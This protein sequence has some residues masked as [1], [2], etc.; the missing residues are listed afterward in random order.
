MVAPKRPSSR[1]RSTSGCGYSSACSYRLA[2]GITSRSTKRRTVS[3][4]CAVSCW[5]SSKVPPRVADF[6]MFDYGGQM[7]RIA[8]VVLLAV[9]AAA[10]RERVGAHP[11]DETEVFTG[12][13]EVE[14]GEAPKR[15]ALAYW[16]VRATLRVPPA[17]R[18]VHVGL[19]VPLS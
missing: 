9:T 16:K 7:L 18:A 14:P 10:A 5:R 15:P 4:T 13:E 2:T 8:A 17:E 11:S 12:G 19:F 3:R 1:M 6:T